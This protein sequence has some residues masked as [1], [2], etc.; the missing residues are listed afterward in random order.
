VSRG[1]AV[2]MALVLAAL[3]LGGC[4]LFE[5]G[6]TA[7]I[8]TA[9]VV[10]YVGE[11]VQFDASA[12]CGGAAL[13]GY[14]WSYGDGA[15]GVGIETEHRF[16]APGSY[17]VSLEVVDARGRTGRATRALLVYV[18]SGTELLR[19]D[20]ADGMTTLD[21]WTL[22]P[23]WARTADGRV[24]YLGAGHDYVLHIAS[25]A[26]PWHRRWREVEVPPLR[27]GQRLRF[28]C[29]VLAARTQDGSG[30]VIHPGRIELDSLEGA[31]SFIEYESEIGTISVIDVSPHGTPV[32][33]H[34]TVE[35]QVYRWTSYRV[36]Y[37]AIG[38]EVYIN[39]ALV[40]SGAAPAGLADGGTYK[41]MLGDESH[42]NRCDVFFDN[43]VVAIV[44]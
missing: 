28:S 2:G 4:T 33:L 30:F 43:V 7:R 24:E 6:P 14:A 37:T 20:F 25:G 10:L 38:Y 1:T 32:P 15:T 16:D 12:S 19:E 17:E 31:L 5:T 23:T 21:A 35:P 13:V 41:V 42:D 27:V 9:P 34:T 26:D 29:E 36:D 8:D 40:A 3:V 39:G 11:T 22:D 18:P 44:E